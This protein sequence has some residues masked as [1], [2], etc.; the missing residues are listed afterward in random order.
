[1]KI[2]RK[3]YV[4]ATAA[5]LLSFVPLPSAAQPGDVEPDS[6]IEQL[7]DQLSEPDREDW[8]RV[9]GEIERVWSRSGSDSMDLLLERGR[10]A[11]SAEDYDTALQYFSALTDHA[12]E[13]AEGWNARATT[14]YLMEEFSLSIADI[15]RVL[16]LN[17][18]H[19]GALQGLGIMF[20]Q[21]GEP[22]LSLRA[23]RAAQKLN[24]NQP[25]VTEAIER[26]EREKGA[27][28]L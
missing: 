11:L 9:Q 19:F 16:A 6:E 3:R 21:M 10:E 8:E 13:F 1:M 14:F 2:F 15:E 5:V 22:D 26:L 20:E 24:P 12:P 27:A 25:D 18:R 7:L 17:P 28:E 4:P 23:F